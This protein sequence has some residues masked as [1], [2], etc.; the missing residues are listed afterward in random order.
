MYSINITA[1]QHNTNATLKVLKTMKCNVVV[2]NSD[3]LQVPIFMLI[4]NGES[5]FIVL[6]VNTPCN[7]LIKPNKK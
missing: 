5:L 1:G 7:K 3:K 6:G 2:E 4:G